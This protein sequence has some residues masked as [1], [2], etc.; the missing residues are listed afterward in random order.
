MTKDLRF[1]AVLA[2]AKDLNRNKWHNISTIYNEISMSQSKDTKT[3]II[4]GEWKRV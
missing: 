4:L 3:I 2:F 1:R